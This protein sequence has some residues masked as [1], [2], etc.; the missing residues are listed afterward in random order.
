MHTLASAAQV[1]LL[2]TQVDL[3]L[4]QVNLLSTAHFCTD[5]QQLEMIN[6]DENDTGGAM[7]AHTHSANSAME[8]DFTKTRQITSCT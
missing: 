2:C 4:K 8:I 1:D 5:L 7:A 6:N 3:L